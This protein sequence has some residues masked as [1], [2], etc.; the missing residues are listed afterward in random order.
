MSIFHDRHQ[1]LEHEEFKSGPTRG[2]LAVT[3][4]VLTD[5]LI[6]VNQHTVY[7]HSTHPARDLAVVQQ[8]I[9]GAKDLVQSVLAEL[10]TK[11][12]R[13]AKSSPTPG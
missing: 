3:L 9:Q 12:P 1:S 10:A 6:L 4:D 2:R 11:Q 7:C 13:T 5:A 8:Q